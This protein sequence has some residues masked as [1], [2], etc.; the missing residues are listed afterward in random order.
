[1]A[2]KQDLLQEREARRQEQE[3]FLAVYDQ[4]K[5]ELMQIPGVI[6]VSVGLRERS[7]AL[8]AEPTFRVE[9]EQKLPQSAVPPEQVIPKEIRGFPTDVITHRKGIPAIGFNDE[10]DDTNYKTKVGG[11]QIGLDEVGSG[12]GTLGCFARLNSDNSVVILSCFHVLMQDEYFHQASAGTDTDKG[13]GQ[14]DYSGSCCC[15]CNEIAKTL[16]GGDKN[17]DCALAKLKPDVKFAPKIKRIKRNNGDTEEAGFIEG[18]DNAVM[19]DEVWKVGARTGLTRGT[20]SVVTPRI[21]VHPKAPFTYF[22]DHGDSGSVVINKL[23]SK[24]VGLLRSIDKEIAAG[25]SLGLATP[26]GAVIA[27]LGI[28]IIT[29]DE[30]Q[31]YDVR[32]WNEEPTGVAGPAT[33]EEVFSAAAERLSG[34]ERGRELVGLVR[35][36]RAEI[37]SL[38]NHRRP[39]TVAW[40]RTQ[41]PAYMAALMRTAREPAYR[42]PE[43]LNGVGREEVVQRMREALLQH[44]SAELRAALRAHGDT[45]TRL[46]LECSAF[47]EVLQA[48]ETEVSLVAQP[49]E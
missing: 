17:L 23:T 18:T 34:S 35:R 10:N 1:M 46:W 13:V 12:T 37:A 40:H 11:S 16:G 43:T 6:E 36:H 15:T 3:R 30:S 7:G 31:T 5:A 26:I 25:G 44:G 28:T 41:G 20:V 14:P 22:A 32:A 42:L 27:R 48:W 29:T 45:F 2:D 49:A 9:V 8:T 39:V 47:D 4:V 38:V 19:N 33:P 21:E 24:V